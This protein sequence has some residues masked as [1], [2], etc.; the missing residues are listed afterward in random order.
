MKNHDPKKIVRFVFSVFEKTS[1]DLKLRLR[2]DNLSQTRF[3][4]GIV[5]LYLEND[6]DMVKVMYKVKENTKSMGK[7]KLRRTINDISKGED[8]M[9]KLGITDSD[10]QDIFDMIEMDMYGEE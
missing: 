9:E 3:F 2:Y 5:K 6:P 7:Q 10:K 8:I 1:A 4:A